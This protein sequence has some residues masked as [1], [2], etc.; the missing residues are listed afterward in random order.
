MI[1]KIAAAAII[2]AVAYIGQITLRD[3]RSIDAFEADCDAQEVMRFLIRAYPY[4]ADPAAL[5]AACGISADRWPAAHSLLR[6]DEYITEFPDGTIELHPKQI[7][8]FQMAV[9]A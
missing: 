3:Q 1:A 9:D 7:N 2:G 8:R 4:G 5:Q 6:R